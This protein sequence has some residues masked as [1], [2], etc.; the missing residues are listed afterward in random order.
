MKKK[1]CKLMLGITA[2]AFL[3]AACG[4]KETTAPAE[5]SSI[6]E[7]E[8]EADATEEEPSDT[9]EENA[10]DEDTENSDDSDDSMTEEEFN[11]LMA[12]LEETGEV[13]EEYRFPTFPKPTC[14]YIG[15]TISEILDEGFDLCGYGSSSWGSNYQIMVQM[16]KDYA[17][18]YLNL[19]VDS[20]TYDAYQEVDSDGK[21]DFI[22]D[23]F[24]EEKATDSNCTLEYLIYTKSQ[25]EAC[26][27]DG[28]CTRE[29]SMEGKTYSELMAEGYQES[30]KIS[31]FG[32]DIFIKFCDE[33]YQ[34]GYIILLDLSEKGEDVDTFGFWSEVEP[35]LSD[36]TVMAAYAIK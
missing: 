10:K 21:I 1:L 2:A 28:N 8:S 26:A 6:E 32:D 11:E 12:Q 36:Y 33:N 24:I 23:H 29:T 17:Y 4:D 14:P 22:S 15:L 9:P 19:D 3:L 13:P 31:S 20:E 16:Q 30:D 27:A 18:L 35:R 25:L 5:D 7:E 34:Q